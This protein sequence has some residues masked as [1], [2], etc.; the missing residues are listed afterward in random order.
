MNPIRGSDSST[1][2]PPDL[3]SGLIILIRHQVDLFRIIQPICSDNRILVRCC[4]ESRYS[5][6]LY[7][8]VGRLEQFSNIPVSL[9]NKLCESQRNDLRYSARDLTE[10]ITPHPARPSPARSL[11]SHRSL[12]KAFRIAPTF[13]EALSDLENRLPILFPGWF[14]SLL[15]W[16]SLFRAY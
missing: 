10:W 9:L 1:Y 6:S 15:T 2:F 4:C 13:P 12:P 5:K 16:Q 11:I 14:S 8:R 3:Q 7:K